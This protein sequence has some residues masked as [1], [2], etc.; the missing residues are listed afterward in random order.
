VNKDYSAEEMIRDA[1]VMSIIAII[2]S[3]ITLIMVM[4]SLSLAGE[5]NTESKDPITFSLALLQT[6]IA[7]GAFAGF[8]LVRS[9]SRDAAMDAAEESVSKFVQTEEFE[10]ILSRELLSPEIQSIIRRSS[11]DASLA[12]EGWGDD[13]SDGLPDQTIAGPIAAGAVVVYIGS[14]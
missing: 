10:R 2:S 12:I 8:W 1:K 14:H 6:I 3:L 13:D 7:L 5:F 9:S 11:R 4:W